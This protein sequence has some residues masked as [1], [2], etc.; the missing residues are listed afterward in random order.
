MR[1]RRW[2]API[3][4]SLTIVDAQRCSCASLT[5]SSL[6]P[7]LSQAPGL[8]QLRGHGH[9]QKKRH[10]IPVPFLEA[11]NLGASNAYEVVRLALIQSL[12][13]SSF[14]PVFALKVFSIPQDTP[15]P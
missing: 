13:L 2:L 9:A 15:L 4:Y 10:R 11:S 12:T 8:L 14:A 3:A 5:R 6:R 7:R 1:R